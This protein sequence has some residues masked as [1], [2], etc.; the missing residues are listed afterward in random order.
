MALF[1]ENCGK[2][3]IP[4]EKKVFEDR[5]KELIEQEFTAKEMAHELGVG[6]SAIY[7]RLDQM[8][9]RKIFKLP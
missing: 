2:V 6:L 7:R 1:C 9:A 8:G 3:W 5:L 4:K